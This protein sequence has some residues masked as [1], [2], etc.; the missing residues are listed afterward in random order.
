M[1]ERPILHKRVKSANAVNT[2]GAI[3][4]S[5]SSRI[6]RRVGSRFSEIVIEHSVCSSW[7]VSYLLQLLGVLGLDLVDLIAIGVLIATNI[8]SSQ[9][10][11]VLAC[12]TAMASLRGGHCHV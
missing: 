8:S 12:T 6:S 2:S 4:N 1:L 7:E 10:S 3:I 11:L 5:H 9:L